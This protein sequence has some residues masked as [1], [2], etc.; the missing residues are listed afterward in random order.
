MAIRTPNAPTIIWRDPRIEDAILGWRRYYLDPKGVHHLDG[1]EPAQIRKLAEWA[2]HNAIVVGRNITIGWGRSPLSLSEDEFETAARQLRPVVLFCP[3]RAAR[4]EARWAMSVNFDG[5][6]ETLPETAVQKALDEHV[7]REYPNWKP[8]LQFRPMMA[9][10]VRHDVSAEELKLVEPLAPSPDVVCGSVATDPAVRQAYARWDA[11]TPSTSRDLVAAR[12]ASQER[13]GIAPD[14]RAP[15][16]SGEV[17]SY[18]LPIIMRMG[19]DDE[20][21]VIAYLRRDLR[22]LYGEYA[23]TMLQFMLRTYRHGS[24]EKLLIEAAKATAVAA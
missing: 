23:E 5:V 7:A 21:A 2:A 14:E 11:A 16:Y 3:E 10:L 12:L 4:E 17:D 8:K 24:T 15:L 22:R 13:S 6:A 20:P 1:L 18:L 9:L 19:R